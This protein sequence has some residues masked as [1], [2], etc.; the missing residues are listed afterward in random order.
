MSLMQCILPRDVTGLVQVTQNRVLL[1]PVH[2]GNQGEFWVYYKFS[3]SLLTPL[4]CDHRTDSPTS[5][6]RFLDSQL[7]LPFFTRWL[8]VVGL[9]QFVFPV[10]L[11][12]VSPND[13]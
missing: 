5:L 9:G 3:W 1:C 4:A 11:F 10:L 7:R 12:N 8:N 6:L 13:I 2:P